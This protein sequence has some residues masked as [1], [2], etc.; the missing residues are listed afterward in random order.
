VLIMAAGTYYAILT[1]LGAGFDE[2]TH[3]ARVWEIAQGEVIPNRYLGQGARFPSAFFEVSYRQYRNMTPVSLEMWRS[4]MAVR[5]DPANMTAHR[6]RSVYFP[7]LY[8]PQAIVMLIVVRLLNAPVAV[9]YYLSRLTSVGLYAALTFYAI[10]RLPQGRW[11]LAVLALAPMAVIQAAVVSPDALDNGVAFLFAA[12]VLS[13]MPRQGSPLSRREFLTMLVLIIV[14]CAG[15]PATPILLLLL[16]GVPRSVYGSRAR[17]IGTLSAAIGSF[18]LIT[19]GWN[20]VMG[21]QVGVNSPLPGVQ[22]ATQLGGMVQH[23]LEFAQT[24]A[25]TY[26]A[27]GSRLLTEWIGVTGYAAWQMPPVIYLLYP[28]LLLYVALS[29]TPGTFLNRQRRSLLLLTFL[30]HAGAVAAFLYAGFNPVG[31]SSIAGIQGRYFIGTALLLGLALLPSRQILRRSTAAIA[32]VTSLV[33]SI[34]LAAT[35]LAYHTSCG[36]SWFRRGLCYLPSYKNWGPERSPALE[37][38][39]AHFVWQ[40]F[41]PECN[42]LEQVRVWTRANRK[43]PDGRFKITL[44]DAEADEVVAETQYDLSQVPDGGWLEF[45]FPAIPGSMKRQF[46]LKLR[47]VDMAAG[48]ELSLVYFVTDEYFEGHAWRDGNDLEGDL[49]FQYGCRVGLERLLSHPFGRR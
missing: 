29:E 43:S 3:F 24:V 19:V 10:R 13:I 44:L 8:L 46:V 48:E 49:V 6:T 38:T 34:V 28:V 5:V 11:L 32:V 45:G 33:L 14:L 20:V 4:M 1:P 39:S 37:V 30:A 26:V 7:L 16:L 18:L 42:N 47:P 2:D 15:K 31:S 25:R 9:L 40:D 23:P 21:L 12:W 35:T 22:A 41:Q 17:W 36:D 27:E